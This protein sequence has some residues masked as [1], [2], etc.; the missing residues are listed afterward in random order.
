VS[1]TARTLERL[2]RQGWIA[3]VVERRLP[4][5]R[6]VTQD[7]FGFGDVLAAHPVERRIL[8][9]QATS[10]SNAANR[11]AKAKGKP[12]LLHWIRAGGIFQV[13]AWSKR[14]L[15]WEVRIV[16]VVGEDLE[17]V[18]RE[19]PRR[20]TCRKANQLHFPGMEGVG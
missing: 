1:P 18:V 6:F 16:E 20:R 15:R 3:C 12:E 19:R 13:W 14:G 11:V 9:A 2:R 4:I 7:A 10:A 8:L 5:A 17:P